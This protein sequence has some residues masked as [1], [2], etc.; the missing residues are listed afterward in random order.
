[1]RMGFGFNAD[2]SIK[3]PSSMQARKD[4]EFS[5]LRNTRCI[6]VYREVVSFTAPKK[7]M[8]RIVLSDIVNDNRFVSTIFEQF[9]FRAKVPCSLQKVSD[10]EFV[11][12]LGTDFRRCSDCNSLISA[13][14]EFIGNVIDV[15]GACTFEGFKK[16]FCYEDHFE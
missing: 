7:C 13:Y 15:K 14:R 3:L 8:L 11:V 6:K 2:G 16:S 4:S 5:M 12:I 9:K 1:M 10:K